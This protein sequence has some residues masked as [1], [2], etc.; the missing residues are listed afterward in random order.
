MA[1]LTVRVVRGVTEIP[2][3]AW[4][5]L[6]VPGDTPFIDWRWLEALEHAG[7][8]APDAG[9]LPLHLTLWRGKELV[10]AAPGYV[11]LDSDGDFGRDWDWA[12]AAEDA[13]L[14][15]YP[16]LVISVPFTPVTGRRL[17]V[18]PGE[19]EA[20]ATAA[21]TAAA[22][23]LVKRERLG[24]VHVLFSTAAQAQR[25]AQLGLQP[26]IG[27]QYH[28]QNPGYASLEAFYARFSS[29]RRNAIRREAGAAA[30]QGIT[31]RTVRGD[32]LAQDRRRW[33]DTAHALHQSTVD[34]LVWGRRWLNQAFYRRVFDAMPGPMELVVAEREGR[35]VAGAFNVASLGPEAGAPGTDKS[36][37]EPEKRLFGRYWGCLEEHPFLH[38]NVC[39][40]HTIADCIRRGVRVF[41]GGAGGEHKISRGFE[42]AETYS[43]HAFSHP[44]LDAA[45]RRH[46]EIE[47]QKRSEALAQWRADAPVL[48]P[49]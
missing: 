46:L 37:A 8:A 7:C 30:Q 1:G 21:L 47:A 13:G 44:K 31:L 20:E 18:A 29:K 23:E 16:K 49:L 22:F 9:W 36:G 3:E 35:I 10:G 34:K 27:I 41:E 25:L 26:R 11:K 12:A 45:L 6:L 39:Y 4:N 2:R 40:Y 5:R 28:W 38:F 42:P 15:Y 24:S 32:E 19:D 48:K 43:A 14:P 17:L 33:A